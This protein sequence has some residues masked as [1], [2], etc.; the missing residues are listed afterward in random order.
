MK[1]LITNIKQLIQIRN[2]EEKFIKGKE[3]K[4]LPLIENAFLLIEDNLIVDF[5]I[6]ENQPKDY[7]LLIDACGGV[8]MPTWCDSHSHIVYAGDR[9]N[10]FVDRIN[11]LSYQEIASRGGGIL[12]SA[13]KLQE[14]DFEILYEDAYKRALELIKL[15]TGA[16]EIKSGYG[17]TVDGEI[18][19]LKVIQRL[20]KT[21][22][23]PVK[24][25]FLG[26]HAFPLAYKENNLHKSTY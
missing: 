24:A 4:Q 19:I 21:L 14:T 16:L 7:D 18:K 11:G 8:V 6:K 2:L 26:A 10:E 9:I 15:G 20:K 17:L 13:K 3:M 22:E 12:N 25:T 1:T 5:G 23:I